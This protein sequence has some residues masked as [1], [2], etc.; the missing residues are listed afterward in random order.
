[1]AQ[2][3]RHY[4][5]G[6]PIPSALG[7]FLRS[8]RGCPA[9]HPIGPAPGQGMEDR[10]Q[11]GGCLWIFRRR[12]LG[13]HS[14]HSLSQSRRTARQEPLR[15]DF[16][17]ARLCRFGLPRGDHGQTHPPRFQA[18]PARQQPRPQNSGALFQREA[19]DQ[20]NPAHLPSPCGQRPAGPAGKQPDALR[21][22]AKKQHSIQIHGT[23]GWRS[24][25][26]W[27]QRPKLGCLAERFHPMAQE[28]RNLEQMRSLERMLMIIRFSINI[29]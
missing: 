24:W 20:G 29:H 28:D 2:Q 27:I 3:P 25:T 19:G 7:S 13:L 8:S 21:R 17:P 16:L 5:C 12:T 15:P 18:Q 10:R 4:R 9:G 11:Q 6:A 26:E 1:M 22:P 14:G 23:P